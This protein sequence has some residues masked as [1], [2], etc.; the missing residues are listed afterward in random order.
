[1]KQENK[2]TEKVSK[3]KNKQYSMESWMLANG[4]VG[5]VFYSEKKDRHITAI[6]THYGRRISTERILAVS[7]AKST[8]NALYIV[9]VTIL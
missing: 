6:A 9:R 3:R 1:M 5:A 7:T 8:P 2:K 4:K